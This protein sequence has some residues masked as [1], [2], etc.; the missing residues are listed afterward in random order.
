MAVLTAPQ[1]PNKYWPNSLT[2]AH[3]YES[4]CIL[5]TTDLTSSRLAFHPIPAFY[6]WEKSTAQPLATL[7]YGLRENK[8]FLLLTG[9]VGTGKTTL[10]NALVG[11][12]GPEVRVA[13]MADPGL[14]KL[15]FLNLIAE[16]L[17]IQ[18][19]FP[20][21]GAFLGRLTEFLHDSREKGITVLL[22]I[23]EAQRLSPE[24]LEEIRVLSNIEAPEAKLIQI[25]LVG[26]SELNDLIRAPRSQALRQRIGLGYHI[27]PLSREE[28]E[29][30]IDH[31]LTVAGCAK[32]P[33]SGPALAQI[34]RATGGLPRLINILCDHALLTGYV[35]EQPEINPAII[36]ECAAELH[37]KNGER[38]LP[39]TA[40]KGAGLNWIKRVAADRRVW[41]VVSVL[42]AMALGAG[43]W[44]QFL[45]WSTP[46]DQIHARSQGPLPTSARPAGAA[47]SPAPPAP[48]GAMSPKPL[49]G[50]D[51][52]A[53][54]AGQ[55]GKEKAATL[56]E[57]VRTDA[58]QAGKESPDR[59][60]PLP[61]AG[62]AVIRFKKNAVGLDGD[63]RKEIGPV[64]ARMLAVSDV[65]ARI[66]GYT[67][68]R[69]PEKYNRRIS[70]ER[71]DMVKQY[72]VDKGIASERI[73]AEGRGPENPLASNDTAAGRWQN[74]RVE[75][76]LIR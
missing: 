51:G 57:K 43:L 70:A 35:K 41:A 20:T 48:A 19:P 50:R 34:H 8:G 62:P 28:T 30:Y 54:T 58:T 46:H 75:I 7:E 66:L 73:Q 40:P 39:E 10:I 11:N 18:G 13:N 52:K 33:F 69:G 56:P 3:P 2:S 45:F 15:D 17:G 53:D 24:L 38:R 60:D 44:G 74:R 25:F 31:R 68:S 63:A 29:A 64:L 71:A 23:D 61:L 5:P 49:T 26:Q 65:K 36:K 55:G 32:N 22:I 4:S 6:G 67:D 9:D 59:S 14:E 1:R 42:M 76:E 12:L 37:L 16:A 47:V 72:L 27:E 21:K